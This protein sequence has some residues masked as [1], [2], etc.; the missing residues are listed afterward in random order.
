MHKKG[1][2]S[3]LETWDRDHYNVVDKEEEGLKQ[4]LQSPE[5]DSREQRVIKAE[6]EELQE[7]NRGI[8]ITK[9]GK[10]L[11][12]HVF[13][14]YLLTRFM[15]IM[16]MEKLAFYN[17]KQRRY[18]F[19]PESVERKFFAEVLGEYDSSLWSPGLE[20]NYTM[21]VRR[22]L[23]CYKQYSIPKG[24][25]FFPN[26]YLDLHKKLF[27]KTINYK[28]IN[29][30]SLGFMYDPEADCPQFLEFLRDIFNNDQSVIDNIQEIFGYTFA[31][32]EYPIQKFFV[33]YGKGRNGKGILTR[34]LTDLHSEENVSAVF[35]DDLSERFGKQNV[36]DKVLNISGEREQKK[37]LDTAVIKTLTGGDLI[38]VEL[39]YEKS[40]SIRISCKFIICCN[41]AIKVNND[42][43]KGFFSRLHPINFPNTYKELR[44][45]ESKEEGVRYEDKTIYSKLKE[46][47]PGIFNWAMEG[48]YRLAENSWNMTPCQAIDELK[49][50]YY[51]EANPVIHFFS[52][53]IQVGDEKKII[54]M[55]D[56]YRHYL[57]WANK[58]DIRTEEF[59]NKREFHQAFRKCM[60][61]VHRSSQAKMING[62]NYYIGIE[63]KSNWK[64]RVCFI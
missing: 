12:I 43:S 8:E 17:F 4:Q 30:S 26:G 51:Y 21:A 14:S 25:V 44:V 61:E 32:G 2:T 40:F 60:E 16:V 64:Q 34:L 50:K 20:G 19:L 37:P 13:T 18:Q 11:D 24:V 7:E 35:L 56:V 9:R 63:M 59:T 41:Q 57:S 10:S 15:M 5:L 39:K 53:C 29:F 49:Q 42:S 33:F 62:T 28:H 22:R 36:Y 46:E 54:S 47:L 55:P 1:L 23:V 52:A 27:E 48:Y 58:H 3:T 45:G 31:Y 38:D 6:L